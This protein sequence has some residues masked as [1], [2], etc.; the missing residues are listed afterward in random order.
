MSY[1]LGLYWATDI[2][3]GVL[4]CGFIRQSSRD[5]QIKSTVLKCECASDGA[6]AKMHCVQNDLTSMGGVLAYLLSWGLCN[7]STKSSVET[8]E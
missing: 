5:T 7:C 3:R 4:N 1:H 8:G 6:T 2:R